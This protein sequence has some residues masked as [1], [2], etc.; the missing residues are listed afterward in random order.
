M[1][2]DNLRTKR[3]SIKY[4]TQAACTVLRVDQ[5]SVGI[6][7]ASGGIGNRALSCRGVGRGESDKR[8]DAPATPVLTLHSPGTRSSWPRRLVA[9]RRPS[10]ARTTRT[11]ADMAR[12]WCGSLRNVPHPGLCW[13]SPLRMSFSLCGAARPG[14]VKTETC[15]L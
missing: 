8:Q 6:E 7:R 12:R 15:P 3:W 2:I 4:A 9:P 13:P 11:K 1:I 5:V 10:R 14:V